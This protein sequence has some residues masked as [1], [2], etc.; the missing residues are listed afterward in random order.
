MGN[1]SD[2]Q[3]SLPEFEEAVA[4]LTAF[5]AANAWPT[6][7]VW[8]DSTGITTLGRTIVANPRRS[9]SPK[10]TGDAY[11]FAAARKLGVLLAG[12]A[13]DWRH[14]YCYVWSPADSDEASRHLMPTGLKLSLPVTPRPLLVRRGLRFGWRR[15]L[16]PSPELLRQLLT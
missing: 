4:Q 11:A 12:L 16:G 1:I 3:P 5:L 8:L 2:N 10:A 13:H 6:E 9:L 15:L 14:S 7:I